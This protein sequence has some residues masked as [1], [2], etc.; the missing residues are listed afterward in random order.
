MKLAANF[1]SEE[2]EHHQAHVLGQVCNTKQNPKNRADTK[3]VNDT[4][5]W[6]G[7][8]SSYLGRSHRRMYMNLIFRS[9]ANNCCEKSAEAIVPK[10]KVGMG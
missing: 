8:Y 7:G 5:I 9:T 1:R 6:K 10:K 4:D 3:C 2:H